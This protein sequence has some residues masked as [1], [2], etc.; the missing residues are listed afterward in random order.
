VTACSFQLKNLHSWYNSGIYVA[1][2]EYAGLPGSAPSVGPRADY[3]LSPSTQT[4]AEGATKEFG[5]AASVGQRFVTGSN[6]GM[7]IGFDV[8]VH[9]P[10]NLSYYGYFETSQIRLKITGTTGA[11]G[12]FN[13]GNGG[14]GKIIVTYTSS[15]SLGGA[16]APVAGTEPLN[17]DAY[18]AG[19][20]GPVNVHQPGSSPKVVETW[21]NFGTPT[22][23][24]SFTGTAKYKLLANNSVR[25]YVAGTFVNG[26]SATASFPAIPSGYFPQNTVNVCC[27]VA[28]SPARAQLNTSG[29]LAIVLTP[30]NSAC[31]FVQDFPLD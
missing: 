10:Y 1:F 9:H 15:S 4:M 21:H 14:D 29:V 16:V 20:T 24:T 13:A 12:S 5:L 7:G 3:T 18:A 31:S 28:N 19:W 22:G 8:Y 26:A 11:G 30:A 17:G 25:V 23:V 2:D 27:I 6:N